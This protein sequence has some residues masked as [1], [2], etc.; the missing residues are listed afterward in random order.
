MDSIEAWKLERINFEGNH[1]T[2]DHPPCAQ[3]EDSN[4]GLCAGKKESRVERIGEVCER[5]AYASSV[6]KREEDK[7]KQ[8]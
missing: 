5:F 3:V 4:G 8:G 1:S 6:K 7:R 2:V